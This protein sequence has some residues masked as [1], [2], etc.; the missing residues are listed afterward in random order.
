MKQFI[1]LIILSLSILTAQGQYE[2]KIAKVYD[3]ETFIIHLKNGKTDSVKLW[4]VDSPELGQQF[5]VAAQKNLEKYIHQEVKLEYKTRDKNN[6][7]LAIVKYTN[8]NN[9]IVNLNK[10]LVENGYAWKNKFTDDKKLEKLQK[11]AQKNRKGLWTNS[12]PTPPWV[13][14]KANM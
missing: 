6:Y 12:D 9:E 4:G 13:W 8:K 5:G 1:S 14:R 2:G 7:M 11:Q 10:V 3:G